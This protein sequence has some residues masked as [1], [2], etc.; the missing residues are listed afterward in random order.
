MTTEVD[1][2]PTVR[3]ICATTTPEDLFYRTTYLGRS[4]LRIPAELR[5][6]IRVEFDNHGETV[7]GLPDIYNQAIEQSDVGDI[8]ILMHDDVY[9]HDWYICER[10][11]EAMEQWDIA[12]LAGSANPDLNEPSW[13]LKFS[14]DLDDLGWQDNIER[15]GAVN[16]Y[17]YGAVAPSYYGP[18]PQECLLM[19][20]LFLIVRPYS[21]IA[22]E[23]RFDPKFKFH[24]YDLDFCRSAHLA[25][26][27]LG[28][29]AISVTH[30]SGGGFDTEAFR[31]SAQIYLAKWQGGS[32][33]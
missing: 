10:A 17:D 25:G 12:G 18:A 1:N 2:R 15:S 8:L 29:A 28:T 4:F 26:L 21:L 31:K 23:V 13:G 5:P 30:N 11:R 19:D 3:I 20:G 16:H 6:Q 27:R 33:R 14:P 7:R 9:I 22:H 24:M 32:S